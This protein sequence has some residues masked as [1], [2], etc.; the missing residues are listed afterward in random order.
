MVN[1]ETMLFLFACWLTSEVP[2]PLDCVL[3]YL[4]VPM[5][6]IY[7]CLPA[8]PSN[9]WELNPYNHFVSSGCHLS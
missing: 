1:A 9:N 6:V 8:G 4:V 7:I 5:S 3:I 2:T